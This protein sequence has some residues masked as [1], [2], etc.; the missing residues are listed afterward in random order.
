M[1]DRVRLGMAL[2]LLTDAIFFFF[3]ILAFIY[4][5]DASLH[6][7]AL[8]LDLRVTATWTACLLTS[9][10]SMWRAVASPRRRRLWLGVTITLGVVFFVGQGTEYLRILRDGIA[11]T[12]GLFSTTFFTLAGVHGL[13]LLIGIVLLAILLMVG[14]SAATGVIAMY[15]YFVGVVWIAIFSVVYL[16]TFL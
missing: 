1:R 15:W 5:R 8:T 11:T 10:L 2:F 3:L 13:H 6:T 9:S 14:N 12:Q 7:A 16:W 4:F